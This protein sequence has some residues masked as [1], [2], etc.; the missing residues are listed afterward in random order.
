M[1]NILGISCF[2]HDSAACLIKDGIVAAAAEEE[3]FT[4][5]KH[6]TG[7]PINAINYCLKEGGITKDQINFVAFYEKPLLKFERLLS[8]HLEMFPRSYWPFYKALP[9]WINE[10]IRVPSIIRKKLKYAQPLSS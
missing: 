9:S 1:V 7:F 8:Q 10:K 6:D 3:R 5:K 2:Y 4:R